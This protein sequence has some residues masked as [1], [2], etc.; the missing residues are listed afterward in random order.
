MLPG[1]GVVLVLFGLGA[2]IGRELPS[3]ERPLSRWGIL[4]PFVIGKGAFTNSLSPLATKQELPLRPRGDFGGGGG[5]D[6]GVHQRRCCIGPPR[7]F[8][9]EESATRSC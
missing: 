9:K 6:V 7:W 2:P 1:I 4:G 3:R 5:G 8:A